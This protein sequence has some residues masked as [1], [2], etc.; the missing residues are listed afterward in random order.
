MW[1]T[2]VP[3]EESGRVCG[4]ALIAA[5]VSDCR[6]VEKAK[7]TAFAIGAVIAI[8]MM[9][10]IPKAVMPALGVAPGGKQES[11]PFAIQQVAHDVKY[12]SEDMTQQEKKLISDFLTI[13]YKKIPKAY[14][15]QIAD[16]VK[17]TSLK[18]PDLFSDFMKL[19]LKKTVEHPIGHLESW[20]GLVRGWFS[21]SNNDGSQAIWWFALNLHGIMIRFLEYVPQWPLKAKQK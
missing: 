8:V 18:D 2:D 20:M 16:P 5:D 12:N 9:V 13:D 10:I 4:G 6:I 21:F 3:D 17:G 14:D 19:W 7:A 15:P 1:L 11:I